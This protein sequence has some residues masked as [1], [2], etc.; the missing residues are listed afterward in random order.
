ME[1]K[2][3]GCSS[4]KRVK[5]TN[6]S[7]ILSS[8]SSKTVGTETVM[9]KIIIN[10]PDNVKNVEMIV[11]I[12]QKNDDHYWVKH[13]FDPRRWTEITYNGAIWEDI[14]EENHEV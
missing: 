3:L 6:I 8:N 4:T 12:Y 13:T 2:I 11:E 7:R 10:L 5:T 9:R 1:P 14:Y